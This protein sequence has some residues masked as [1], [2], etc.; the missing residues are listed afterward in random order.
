MYQVE[1]FGFA[2]NYRFLPPRDP[3]SIRKSRLENFLGTSSRADEDIGIR[4]V[5]PNGH[6]RSRIPSY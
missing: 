4:L 5:R 1:P 6:Y 3:A 2:R